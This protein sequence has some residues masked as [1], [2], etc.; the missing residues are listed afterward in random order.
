MDQ[1]NLFENYLYHTGT[2]NHVT[3]YK[4]LVLDWNT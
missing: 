2:L 4:F 1:I 3:L